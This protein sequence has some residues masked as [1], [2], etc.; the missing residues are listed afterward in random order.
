MVT[1]LP[2]TTNMYG[3]SSGYSTWCFLTSR[4]DSPSWGIFLW[5]ILSFF[6]WIWAVI[7]FNLYLVIRILNHLSKRTEISMSLKM[8]VGKLC[9]YPAVAI[10]C[11]IPATV[12]NIYS[13]SNRF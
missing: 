2:L 13:H 8:Q 12:I 4:S 7:F 1:L 5:D 3:K 9:L 11:W 10:I 6:V